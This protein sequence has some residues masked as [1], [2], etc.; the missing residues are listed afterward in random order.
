[1]C[2]YNKK[3]IC[4]KT[5]RIIAKYDSTQPRFNKDKIRQ[6]PYCGNSVEHKDWSCDI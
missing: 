4:T 3:V 1:M 2:M 5:G 6:C